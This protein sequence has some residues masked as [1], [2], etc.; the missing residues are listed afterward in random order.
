M[1][2]ILNRYVTKGNKKL[3]Y[4]YTT[5]S[6][7]T[8]AAKAATYMLFNNRKIN[9]IEIDT[10]K[11]WVL[12]LDI[13]DINIGNDKTSCGIEKDSGDDPDVTN[14]LKI[15]AKAEKITK[16]IIITGGIGIG[17]VTKKGL[18]VPVGRYAIN[19][20]PMKMIEEEV[21]KVLPEN[22][23][24]KITIY[25]PEGVNIARKTFNP[26]LGIEGGI[27]IIGTTGIVEPMSEDALKESLALELSILREKNIDKIIFSPGNY[28]RDF[29]L[30]MGL[31]RDLVVKTSNYIGYMIDKAVEYN[32]KK[33]LFIG[34]IG[35][36]AK[37]AG[38]IFNTHSKMAD[39]RMEIL[40]ANCGILGSSKELNKK[41]M[42][43]ITTD[44][45]IGYIKEQ[46]LEEVFN[47]LANKITKKCEERSYEEI[48]FGTIIFSKEYGTLGKSHNF[49]GLME[50]FKNE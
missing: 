47:I 1:I 41:I 27:S 7:A 45:A 35:K 9:S 12:N 13:L 36:M 50:E 46:G 16:G 40:T 44:E 15:Y 6:C 8:G 4:G 10:P 31:D 43:S 23:G 11:G 38:G 5:G 29:A 32:M 24:V 49:D 39:G 28:G 3:R 37:V 30:E 26:K 33:I 21:K 17:K 18:S 25:A 14:K 20:V 19:P 2:K 22:S 48:D 42:N 34:H